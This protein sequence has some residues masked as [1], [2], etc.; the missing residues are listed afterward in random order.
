MKLRGLWLIALLL[1]GLSVLGAANV[2]PT[3][4]DQYIAT[5]QDDPV[6]FEIRAEDMD[7]DPV[8]VTS[9][10]LVFSIVAGPMHGVLVGDLTVITYRPPHTAA[11]EMTYVPADG[12]VGSDYITLSVTDP[13]GEQ[14]L[15]TMTVEI[16]IEARRSLGILSGNWSSGVTY[17][18]QTGGFTAFR[19]QFTGVYRIGSLTMKS[20]ASIQME[21]VS[22]VKR[23]VFKSLRFQSD[24]T[25][26]GI[27]HTSTLSFDPDAG[28]ADLF[29]YWR[30][31]TRF[32]FV[33]ANFTHSLYLSNSQTDSYQ[34][35]SVQARI[36]SV[37]VTNNLTLSMNPSCSFDF[38]N[39]QTSVAWSMCDVA[40]RASI[41]FDCDGFD[42][43]TLSASGLSVY[44]FG[45]LLGDVYID[46]SLTFDMDGKSLSASTYWRPGAVNCI[47]LLAEL[48][49][50][51]EA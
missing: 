11:V 27:D 38:S 41:G 12:Y 50:S 45:W 33:G 2:A 13:L 9:H 18:T 24:F 31:S 51:A 40:A 36:G 8:D 10:P 4:Q 30:T 3:M 16:E 32:S 29:D 48:D 26:A 19:T 15:G 35:L 22:G 7:I 43:F 17:N 21:T 37:S 5:V 28:G 34:A 46:A 14:A 49:L 23:M 25:V 1:I 42:K 20:I 6:T 44:G 39:N 47:K